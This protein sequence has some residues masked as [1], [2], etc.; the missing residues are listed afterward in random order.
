MRLDPEVAR[1]PRSGRPVLALRR[2]HAGSAIPA[3]SSMRPERSS[4]L[5]WHL[6]ASAFDKDAEA[7]D[8][9]QESEARL[10]AMER[11]DGR[12]RSK[13]SFKKGLNS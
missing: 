3:A 11:M 9:H 12:R 5:R 8:P 2:G 13:S 1:K 4:I 10:A 6:P 7:A